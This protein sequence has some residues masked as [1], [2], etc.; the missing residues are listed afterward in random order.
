MPADDGAFRHRESRR[1]DVPFDRAGRL[2]IDL[3]GGRHVSSDRAAD[4]DDAADKIRLDRRTD[5]D[6]EAVLADLDRPLDHAVDRQ[7]TRAD[8]I[9]LQGDGLT[10]PRCDAPLVERLSNRRRAVWRSSVA[11]AG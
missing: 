5:T 7:V 8:D 3:L 2:Q 11:A 10:N 1:R 4:R 9:T 6:H